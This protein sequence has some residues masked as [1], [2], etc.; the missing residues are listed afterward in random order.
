MSYCPKA[1]Q[2]YM[3]ILYDLLLAFTVGAFTKRA[4]RHVTQKPKFY[5]F[6][7]GVFRALRPKR[8]PRVRRSRFRRFA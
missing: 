8:Y 5:F 2:G 3:D 4:R 1:T 7:T 6:D